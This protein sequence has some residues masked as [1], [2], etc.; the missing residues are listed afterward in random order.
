MIE[1]RSR[2]LVALMCDL[3]KL[4]EE[5]LSVIQ[6]KLGAMRRADTDA[7]NSCLAREQ[8]LSDRIRQQE[9]LRQQLVQLIGQEIGISAEA[10]QHLSLRELAEELGE[11]RRAQLLG[12]AGSVREVLAAIDRSNK[13]ATLVT[14]EML[15]HFRRVYAAMARAGDSAGT[16]SPGGELTTDRPARVFEAV[17]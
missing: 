11:P 12:L 10:A 8:F 4:H 15:K 9:G 16:Y 13:V 2:D 6:Q 7:L 14:E 3:K 17:G 5:L 1:S